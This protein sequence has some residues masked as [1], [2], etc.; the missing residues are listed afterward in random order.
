MLCQVHQRIAGTREMVPAARWSILA[1]AGL[2]VLLCAWL[3]TSIRAQNLPNVFAGK[4]LT[5][6]SGGT[7]NSVQTPN[8][9][10]I[11][12]P[13]SATIKGIVEDTDGAVIPG[14]EVAIVD[15]NNTMHRVT[16]ADGHGN[17]EFDDLAP[18]TYRVT[19]DAP[20]VTAS[21]TSTVVLGSGE[22]REVNLVAAQIAVQ[23]TTVEV[24]ASLNEVAQAQ[25]QEQE[26]QR[27][28]G[29][30]P[31][32][33]TSYIWNAAPMTPTLKFKLAFRTTFDPVT[34]LT[35]GAIAGAEQAHNTFPGYGRGPEG[36]AKRYG[37]TYADTVSARM[38][39]SAIFPVLLHQD[40]R[41]FY[42]GSGTIRSRF[43]YALL[44]TVVCRGDNQ[45]LE[46]NYSRILGSFAAAGVSNL[47][48]SPQ[49][50]QASLTFRNGLIIIAG[51]AAENVLREFLS[52]K[53]T[54]NVP[55]FANGKPIV[56]HERQP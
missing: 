23:K 50:R 30:F 49:D 18:G 2:F 41:Y 3:Q 42:H 39:S 44:S 47:Y 46:P 16:M 40:P 54:P 56:K 6:A 37:A 24:T 20:G 14:A 13:S 4:N 17:F 7:E 43:W 29:F 21:A 19:A 31:N 10:I 25:V 35:V 32:Y 9:A 26:Q 33:Y 15:R 1:R 22:R 27:I 5:Q 48:R 28:L 36:Y 38:L 8:A 34:F 11:Q 12:S 51:G 55:A 45:R 53:L 52:R